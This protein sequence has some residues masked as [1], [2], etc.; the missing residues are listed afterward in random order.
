[1]SEDLPAQQDDRLA[2]LVAERDQSARQRSLA[3]RAFEVLYFRHAPLMRAF[4]AARVGRSDVDDVQQVVWQRAWQH[5]PDKFRG[6]NFR[7]WI[8]Q[9]ARNY[10]VDLSRPQRPGELKEEETLADYRH[11]GGCER[12]IEEE[13][14][15][16]LKRCLGN[17][18]GALAE[19]V[20][21]R[22]SGESYEEISTRTGLAP[23]KAQSMF[24]QAKTKLQDCVGRADQ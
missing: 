21:A 11:D 8:H 2:A 15:Q 18:E 19:L 22:L 14:M 16:A 3:V 1:M 12:M 17:L 10:V 5:L 24:H 6:G 23:P 20:R 7:A 13:R 4:L 9:I